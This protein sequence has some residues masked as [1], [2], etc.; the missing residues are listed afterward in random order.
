M[1]VSRSLHNS[2][3]GT[4][5]NNLYREDDNATNINIYPLEANEV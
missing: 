2:F 1:K 3:S 4:G 5:V